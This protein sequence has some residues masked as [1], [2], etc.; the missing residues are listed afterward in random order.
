M[1]ACLGGVAAQ[2]VNGGGDHISG[3]GN[4]VHLVRLGH[5]SGLGG[6]H[7][8]GCSDSAGAGLR[9]C[10]SGSPHIRGPS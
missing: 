3:R 6:S 10:P 9:A 7:R 5:A 8:S 4:D 1:P 2:G